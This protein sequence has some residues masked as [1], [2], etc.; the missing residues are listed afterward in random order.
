M[1]KALVFSLALQFIF[2]FPTKNLQIKPKICN[3]EYNQRIHLPFYIFFCF[4]LVIL[5]PK[6][7]VYFESKEDFDF[8]I[9][10]QSDMADS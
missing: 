7:I 8:F 5:I 9:K 4:T 1:D 3:L 10:F 6:N 2:S